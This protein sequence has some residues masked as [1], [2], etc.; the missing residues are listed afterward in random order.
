MTGTTTVIKK[1][2]TKSGKGGLF[3]GH[4]T[5]ETYQEVQRPLLTP[6]EY[7]TLQGPKKDHED[8]I[9]EAGDMLVFVAGFPTIRGKQILYFQDPVFMERAKIQAPKQSDKINH[10]GATSDEI[11]KFYIS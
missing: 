4:S 7:M 5:S 3:G 9:L 8:K 11:N 6:D 1:A 2:I 10:L